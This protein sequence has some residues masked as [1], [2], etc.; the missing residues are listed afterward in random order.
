MGREYMAIVIATEGLDSILFAKRSDSEAETM[1]ILG[2]EM[3]RLLSISKTGV[4]FSRGKDTFGNETI[5]ACYKDYSH[6]IKYTIYLERKN[7]CGDT[8]GDGEEAQPE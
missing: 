2:E 4:D 1:A 6:H 5:I 3:E 7:L 8:P